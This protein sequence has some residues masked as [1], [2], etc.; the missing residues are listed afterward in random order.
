MIQYIWGG[1]RNLYIPYSCPGQLDIQR[2]W[3][4]WF[5][6]SLST[7][8]L[9]QLS[10]LAASLLTWC[11]NTCQVMAWCAPSWEVWC[12]HLKG[13]QTLDDQWQVEGWESLEKGSFYKNL[14]LGFSGYHWFLSLDDESFDIPNRKQIKMDIWVFMG[15][16]FLSPGL[17][18]VG[19]WYCDLEASR[20]GNISK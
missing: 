11:Q 12:L 1:V 5:W 2:K 18:W 19:F 7:L 15:I 6:T 10:P 4:P 9:A 8:L 17:T 20:N 13:N 16:Y 14:E 3:K